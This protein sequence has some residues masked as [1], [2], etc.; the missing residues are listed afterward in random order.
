[1]EI[2]SR[3]YELSC[4]RATAAQRLQS[5]ELVLFHIPKVG[6]SSI[7][8]SI[9]A[10]ANLQSPRFAVVDLFRTL[11]EHSS[12]ETNSRRVLGR[13]RWI[14]RQRL[15]DV[16]PS[17]L[18][19]HHDPVC[20]DSVWPN[21]RFI[22]QL[23][24][25]AERLLSQY[26]HDVMRTG[27]LGSLEDF[28]TQHPWSIRTQSY[29]L[30]LL[31]GTPQDAVDL[32]SVATYA[33]LAGLMN[34]SWCITLSDYANGSRLYEAL[35]YG[36]GIAV[37]PTINF[38]GTMTDR[39]SWRMTRSDAKFLSSRPIAD[40]IDKERQLLVQLVEQATSQF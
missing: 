15:F 8:R 20:L 36:L 16:A 38:E 33:R 10:G 22:I 7:W 21:A 40:E 28:V 23:R 11:P 17:L 34:R 37:Q 19:H 2:R 13:A 12:S 1:M 27:F 29:W 14:Q 35:M 3:D 25:P 9:A 5:G 18:L 6:G 31:S 30:A 32:D 4:L 26:R 24:E 39:S